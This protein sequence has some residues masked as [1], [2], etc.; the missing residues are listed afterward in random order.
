MT[1]AVCPCPPANSGRALSLRGGQKRA[2]GG[3]LVQCGRLLYMWSALFKM[4]RQLGSRPVCSM[5]ARI[6]LLPMVQAYIHR[7]LAGAAIRMAAPHQ[8][9]CAQPEKKAL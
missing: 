9:F 8:L 2:R 7:D 5:I 6:M 1:K 4:Q 3:Q